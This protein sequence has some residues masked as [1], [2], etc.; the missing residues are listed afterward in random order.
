MPR[1]VTVGLDGSP[2]SR[3]AAEWA[4]REAGL[5]G[6]P[7]KV[8][9]V[10]EPAPH[11]MAR[12][13]FLGAETHQH[14]AE[15]VP[16][17][18]VEGIRL[19]H[20]GIE[21][22]GENV[23]GHPVHV[24]CGAAATADLLVLGTRG[25]GGTGGHVL[26][27]VG[28]AVVA[29]AEWPVVLVRSGEQAADEHEKDPAGVPSTAA[30]FRPVVLGVDTEDPDGTPIGFAFDA[31]VRRAT[32][33]RIVRCWKPAPYH[34]YGTSADAG[35]RAATAPHESA[36]LAE[37]VGPWRQKFPAV[38]VVEESRCGSPAV[39]LVEASREA[40]LVVVGRQARR[41]AFGAH[42]GHVTHAV[43]HHSTAPVAVV[44]HG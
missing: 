37:T 41:S 12:A 4:A 18:A 42:I 34:A 22:T 15:R 21:V 39:C 30:P 3:A 24:L 10:S 43:L 20:P 25:L 40:S 9:H 6:L 33:L 38:D 8:L 35:P 26:G 2:E 1:T 17:D 13:P 27:S 5:R 36:A 31:A 16:R 44:S 11:T 14:W 23:T 19:R 7:L 29:R 28:M 32:T